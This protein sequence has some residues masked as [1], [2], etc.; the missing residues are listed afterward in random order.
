MIKTA[1]AAMSFALAASGMASAAETVDQSQTAV[2]VASGYLGIGGG[3]EQRLAQTFTA[4]RTGDLVALRLPVSGC[5]GGDLVIEVRL[6]GPDGGPDG[7][8]LNTT[9]IDPAL[10]PV[11]FSDL[12]E[13]RLST[14]VRVRTSVAYAFVVRMDPEALTSNCNF[15]HTPLGELY[16]GG[17][18]YYDARPNPPGWVIGAETGARLDLAFET[19]VDTGTPPPVSS[20]NCLSPGV[21]GGAAPIPENLPVC[22]CL[23]DAGLREFRCAL[24]HPDFFAIRRTPWP[25]DLDRPYTETWEVLPLTKLKAPIGLRL[26]G[27]NI[28]QPIDLG[29]KGISRKAVQARSVTLS[30]PAKTLSVKGAAT[31]TYGKE[32]WTLDRSLGADFFK[33]LPPPQQKPP[34]DQ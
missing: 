12:H 26:T 3:S 20:N 1:I 13:F 17:A 4:G 7:A 30:V 14:P 31:L 32:T 22:R 11:I 19:I 5:G 28:S 10:V 16:E 23:R 21:P 34:Y 24:L 27:D 29:F 6:A 9:R 2:D 8:L 25:L 33:A 18:F 15:A